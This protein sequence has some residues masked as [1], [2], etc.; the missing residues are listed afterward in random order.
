[1]RKVKN[2]RLSDLLINVRRIAAHR[3]KGA[4]REIRKTYQKLLKE[5]QHFLADE[6]ARLAKEDRLTYEILQQKKGYTNF[7]E[8]VQ[9]K[10]NSLSPEISKKII[11]IV[12][13]TY[14]VS[15]NG[16]VIAA[17]KVGNL[18]E[19]L[20]GLQLC[21]PEVV[22]KA[23]ENPIAGLTLKDTLEKNRK[24][25][26]YD[27]KKQIGIGITNGDR[28]STMANRIKKSLDEDYKKSIR[29]VRTE[30]HRV[31]NAGSL[32]AALETQKELEKGHC[33]S[34]LVKIWRTMKDERVRPNKQKRNVYNHV[35]ME[36]VQLSIE[37]EFILPSG[38][39][40]MSP[41]NSGVAGEDI[42]CRCYLSYDIVPVKSKKE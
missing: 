39:R 27:I 21:Q 14:E 19:N 38:A 23:I 41:G 31:Q 34:T 1:M 36:G 18:K 11:K 22:K 15:Y 37:E 6:Y 10:I 26:I 32:D 35:A 20:K 13:D 2:N 33:D 5:L 17:K 8:I 16:M 25:I 7:L 40:T 12:Q 30:T 3:R 28:Y 24:N 9:N 29:I 42:Q 4:E